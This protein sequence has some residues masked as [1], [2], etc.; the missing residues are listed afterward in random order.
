MKIAV[1]SDDGKH[2]AHHFGRTR[3][4]LI[5]TTT[6]NTITQKEYL[7]NNFTGHAKGHHHH[8]NDHHHSHGGILDALKDC[9]VVISRG[10]GRRLLDDFELA[11][12]KVFVILTEVADDAVDQYLSGNLLH[13]PDRSCHH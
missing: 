1:A 10:M 4:F 5:F 2:I 13:N 11:G 3:G 7:P 9:E 6:G 8:G 12:K